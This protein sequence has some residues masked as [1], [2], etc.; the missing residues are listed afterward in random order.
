MSKKIQ[1]KIKKIVLK[2]SRKKKKYIKINEK[3]IGDL[4]DSFEMIKFINELEKSFKIKLK[5]NTLDPDN[6]LNISSIK[7]MIEKKLK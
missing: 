1:E 3:I 5:G 7:K 2:L 4:L 6:F